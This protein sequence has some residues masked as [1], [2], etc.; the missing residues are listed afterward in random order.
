MV[1]TIKQMLNTPWK[2]LDESKMYL[3]KVLGFLYLVVYKGVRLSGGYKFYGLPKVLRHRESFI[4]IGKC[5]EN[6]NSWY[7]NPLG[8]NHPT[9]FCTWSKRASIK[10]GNNVGI[11]GGSIVA[12]KSIEIGDGTI[13]EANTVII[14][15]DFHPVKGKNRRYKKSGIR[16]A[17]VRIGKNVFIGMN[18]VILKGVSISDNATI[19]AGSIVR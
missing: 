4:K 18:C 5:F 16:S 10:I 14:D 19:P 2:V 3:C 6:R 13:I 15:T 17:P 1:K 11:S 8:I 12:S 7:S 9:I